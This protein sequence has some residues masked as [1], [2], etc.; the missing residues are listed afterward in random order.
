MALVSAGCARAESGRISHNVFTN[1]AL[2]AGAVL[3][4]GDIEGKEIRTVSLGADAWGRPNFELRGLNIDISDLDLAQVHVRMVAEGDSNNK[5]SYADVGVLTSKGPGFTINQF[6]FRSYQKN[7]PD[8]MMQSADRS[9]SY[10]KRRAGADYGSITGLQIKT[11]GGFSMRL[12]TVQVLV[13]ISKPDKYPDDPQPN[14][15][16]R[17]GN[18]AS[19]FAIPVSERVFLNERDS[20]LR[21]A[22]PVWQDGRVRLSGAS[23]ETVAFQLILQA[24]AGPNGVNGVDVKFSGLANGSV[25]I[26]NSRLV[27]P[28][29]PYDYIGRSIQ[30]Y[31]SRYVLYDHHGQHGGSPRAANTL[32]KY[33]PEI[34]IPFEAKWGGAP[35]SIFPDQTQAVWADIYIPRAT[36]AGKYRGQI[37]VLVAGQTIKEVPV[38]LEVHAFELPDRFSTLGLMYSDIP[39]KHGAETAAQKLALEKTYRQ[40]FRRHHGGMFRGVKGASDLSPEQ[41]QL[42][43]GDIYTPSQG[44]EGPGQGLP[45]RFIFLKMYGGGLKPFG[46]A[47]ISGGE[48]DWHRGLLEYKRSA[49][50][51]APESLLAYYVW[52]EPGHAFKGGIPAFTGWFNT[53]VAPRVTSFNARYNADIKLY[54]SISAEDAKAMP[55]M[56]I[57]RGVTREEALQMEREGDINCSWNGPQGLGHFA[58]ALRVVGW[59]AFYTRTSF[60]WMWHATAYD[61]AFDVY[62]DPYNFRSPYGEEGAGV[63]MFVYPGTDIY[64]E[65]RNPGLDGPVPGSRFMNWRQGFIDAQYLQLAAKKDA[66]ATTAIAAMM[67]SGAILNSGLPGEQASVG[68][69]IG[70]DH[71]ASARRQLV[72]IILGQQIDP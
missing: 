17:G 14:P 64:I 9:P 54:S 72:D 43:A 5:P 6:P 33:I 45:T 19:V 23:N 63:G 50:K 10:A 34:Q 48:A 22:N 55:A 39:G 1:G 29:D 56:D 68:Y 65:K 47:G 31:R 26:D 58:S 46:G 27:N 61:N 28:A 60:W 41:W 57:Y 52:D 66:A 7:H 18:I 70:E 16:W 21:E 62:R 49:D 36:P 59:K 15:D 44:Y 13:D 38:E 3:I 51:Y 37:E 20:P 4:N 11:S 12:S 30:L 35:F 25:R 32:G 8:Y 24:A 67:V 69:P 53:Q 71:Y 40:F 2:A 42:R